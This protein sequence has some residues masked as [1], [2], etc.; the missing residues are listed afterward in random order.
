MVKT[1]LPSPP[2]KVFILLKIIRYVQVGIASY[3]SS[4]GCQSG[5]PDGYARVTEFLDYITA[6]TG[7]T[8]GE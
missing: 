1:F 6:Q 2:K 3:V 4:A 5:F 8:Q 7:K